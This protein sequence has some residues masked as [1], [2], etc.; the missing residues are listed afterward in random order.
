MGIIGVEDAAYIACMDA[1]R[2]RAVSPNVRYY[3]LIRGA[4]VDP[5]YN[6]PVDDPLYGG[7]PSPSYKK[8]EYALPYVVFQ[9]SIE[10]VEYDNAEA[11]ATDDGI[12]YEYDAVM[13]I[14]KVNWNVVLSGRE[15]KV[16]DVVHVKD[17]LLGF[18]HW[19][20]I[21]KAGKNGS[22]ANT[23]IAAGWRVSLKSRSAFT[24][25]RKVLR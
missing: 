11:S 21:V 10:Y 13:S 5:L 20:S 8:W 1:E 19:F 22:I 24:P 25:D 18:D 17:D 6:E 16:G 2:Q 14:S 3:R 9:A 4:N 15:P 12:A 7:S 23:N